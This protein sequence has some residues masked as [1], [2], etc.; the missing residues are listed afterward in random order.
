MSSSTSENACQSLATCSEREL[1]NA[2]WQLVTNFPNPSTLINSCPLTKTH[3]QPAQRCFSPQHGGTQGNAPWVDEPAALV[4]LLG[5]DPT[6][7]VMGRRNLKVPLSFC[8]RPSNFHYMV[9]S[10]SVSCYLRCPM[11]T[12]LNELL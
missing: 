6:E 4:V 10:G 7:E 11:T 12:L 2:K 8:L 3:L 1:L 5:C 9:F